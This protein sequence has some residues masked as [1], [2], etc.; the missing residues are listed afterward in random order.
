MTDYSIYLQLPCPFPPH[1]EALFSIHSLGTC[2]VM[3]TWFHLSW[4]LPS[5]IYKIFKVSVTPQKVTWAH[6]LL[7]LVAP[8]CKLLI[9]ICHLFLGK[10]LPFC[11][12]STKKDCS[13]PL[14]CTN[15]PVFILLVWSAHQHCQQTTEAHKISRHP[16]MICIQIGGEKI[17][18]FCNYAVIT[19]HCTVAI[20]ATSYTETVTNAIQ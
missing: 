13:L 15:N 17:L 4:N 7:K 16:A 19:W 11:L 3:A 10:A 9:S 18:S 5:M 6:V 20:S 8:W 14:G 12:L 2:H 1:L